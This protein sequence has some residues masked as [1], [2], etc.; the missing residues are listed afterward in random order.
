MRLAGWEAEMGKGIAYL[1]A[2]I[3]GVIVVGWVGDQRAARAWSARCR[4]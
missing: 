4:T 2:M 1:V 3:A